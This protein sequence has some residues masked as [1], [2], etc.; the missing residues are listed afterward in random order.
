MYSDFDMFDEIRSGVL[1]T[2]EYLKE[3]T[4][5]NR[6]NNVLLMRCIQQ[7][8]AYCDLP[9]RIDDI[10]GN[11]IIIVAPREENAI[12]LIKEMISNKGNN[13]R[14]ISKDYPPH[15]VSD[16]AAAINGL[17]DGDYLFLNYDICFSFDGI[18]EM[19]VDV[20]KLGIMRV[21]IGNGKNRKRID[22]DAPS[23]KFIIY[24]SI[25]HLLSTDVKHAINNHLG[26]DD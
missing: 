13:I 3:I 21:N 10:S 20:S 9:D 22:L 16:I 19:I 1:Q 18:D 5:I 12:D 25:P 17:R 23:I 7:S 4:E 24:T 6:R 26:F 2:A 14:L 11:G 15:S 8:V